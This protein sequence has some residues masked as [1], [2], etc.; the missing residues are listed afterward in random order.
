MSDTDGQE[1]GK[2]PRRRGGR[3]WRWP[4]TAL[5]LVVEAILFIVVIGGTALAWRAAQG[6]V[7]L[8]LLLPKIGRAIAVAAPQFDVSIGHLAVAWQGF[9]Q[10]PDQP[11]QLTGAAIRVDDPGAGRRLA[12]DGMSLDLSAAWAVRGVVAPRSITLDGPSL[13]LR[14]GVTSQPPGGAQP[15]EGRR[16]MTARDIITVLERPPE[17]DRHLVKERPAAL[18]ELTRGHDHRR[19]GAGGTLRCDADGEDAARR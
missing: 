7:D 17:T 2:R 1:W 16:P 8:S 5:I 14:R 19:G 9:T 3:W 15:S 11:V 12:V 10:G 6:P 13:M 4:G 18:S